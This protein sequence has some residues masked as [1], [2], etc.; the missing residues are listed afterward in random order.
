MYPILF[1]IGRVVI[2]SY[3]FLFAIAFLV[4]FF[5]LRERFKKSGLPPDKVIDLVILL[6]ISGV[7]GAR[8]LHVVINLKYYLSDPI[9][10]IMIHHGGSAWQGGLVLGGFAGIMFF[11]KNKFAIMDT[12]DIVIPYVALSQSIGRIGCFLNGCCY[13]KP[14]NSFLGVVF[15]G[16]DLPVHPVQIYNS[17]NLV[18]IFL[19]L[20]GMQSKK[21]FQGQIF[22][23]YFLLSSFTRF[24]IDFLRGDL[25]TVLW[26]LTISQFI[27]ISIFSISSS[28]YLKRILDAEEN[29]S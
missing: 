27:S 1:K 13:G 28:I 22:L 5:L 7:I 14:T 21:I 2:Y 4:G 24:F 18:I 15:P 3:G 11:R 16:K 8:L 12:C 17:L 20:R 6:L 29:R 19:V 10:I 9:E 26:N 25:G 23:M